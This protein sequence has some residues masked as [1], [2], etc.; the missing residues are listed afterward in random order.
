LHRLWA[1]K[2]YLDDPD[3]VAKRRAAK[4]TAAAEETKPAPKAS[5]K[6]GKLSY[7]GSSREASSMLALVTALFLQ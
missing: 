3:V 1:Q 6:S 7:Y 2:D 5:R 4:A